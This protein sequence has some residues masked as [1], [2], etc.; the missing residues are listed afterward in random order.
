MSLTLE[1][2][3]A[4]DYALMEIIEDDEH[5]DKLSPDVLSQICGLR[6][7]IWSRKMDSMAKY[8]SIKP[9]TPLEKK[10]IKQYMQELADTLNTDD[11]TGLVERG[12]KLPRAKNKSTVVDTTTNEVDYAKLALSLISAKD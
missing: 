3:W 6:P 11:K 12:V 10:N 4:L 2:L 8:L 5:I 9:V 1:E 7:K